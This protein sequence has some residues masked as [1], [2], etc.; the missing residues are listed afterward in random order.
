MVAHVA[1][2]KKHTKV[3][4]LQTET[5][6]TRPS[7]SKRLKQKEPK[8]DPPIAAAVT[9]R[10]FGDACGQ[11][12]PAGSSNEAGRVTKQENAD[13]TKKMRKQ[14]HAVRLGEVKKTGQDKMSSNWNA[15]GRTAFRGTRTP[16]R[17]FYASATHRTRLRVMA[18][19]GW[20]LTFLRMLWAYI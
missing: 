8:T 10:R 12:K 2:T 14:V 11:L 19:Y 16:Y 17:V 4:D 18:M 1:K 3:Q 20:Y 15:P 7:G 13:D 5:I 6:V 9:R